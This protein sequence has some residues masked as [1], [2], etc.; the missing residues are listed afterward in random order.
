MKMNHCFWWIEYDYANRRADES[1]YDFTKRELHYDTQKKRW[2][3]DVEYTGSC[4]PAVCV[5]QSYKAALRHVRKHQEI[6]KGSI[7]RVVSAYV[8]CDRYIVKK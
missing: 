5:C 2:V 1:Y 8:G 6:P 3:K 7:M 4:Y